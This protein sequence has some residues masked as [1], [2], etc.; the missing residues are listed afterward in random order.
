MDHVRRLLSVNQ[1]L[2]ALETLAQ[3]N[4]LQFTFGGLGLSQQ[5]EIDTEMEVG[6]MNSSYATSDRTKRD[7]PQETPPR[8]EGSVD[9]IEGG[10]KRQRIT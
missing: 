4:F 8:S 6:S 10:N 1:E 9:S 7:P 2:V 5:N 3:T